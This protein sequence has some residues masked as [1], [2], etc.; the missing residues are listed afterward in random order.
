MALQ[1][2]PC[3]GALHPPKYAGLPRFRKPECPVSKHFIAALRP[4]GK[5]AAAV[6]RLKAPHHH[7]A[8]PILQTVAI[9]MVKN[10]QDIIEPFLRHHAALMDLVFVLENGS[11][12][13]TRSIVENLMH[14][15]GNIVMI[16]IPDRAQA[17]SRYVSQTL[18][19]V[20][21]AVFA[22]AVFFLDADEFIH[23]QSRAAL[24]DQVAALP[25]GPA[26]PLMLGRMPWRTFVP[27]PTLEEMATPDPLLR[28]RMRRKREVLRPSSSKVFLRLGGGF[29]ASIMC[30]QGNHKLR[31]G[32]DMRL[33]DRPTPM[34]PLLHLPVRSGAQLRVKA[35]AGWIANL[36]R[37]NDP[38][39]PLQGLDWKRLSADFASRSAPMTPADLA[40]EAMRYGTRYPMGDYASNAVA[41]AHGITPLRRYSDGS[42]GTAEALIEAARN[43]RP[44]HSQ[45]L[46]LPSAPQDAA[47][48]AP[49]LQY[50]MQLLRPTSVLA[51]HE[52]YCR[53]ARHH[54]AGDSA[55]WDAVQGQPAPHVAD[56]VLALDMAAPQ[57]LPAAFWDSCSGA[58][59]VA[60]ACAFPCADLGDGPAMLCA[61]VQWAR[62]GWQP[63]LLKTLAFRAVS[64]LPHLRRTALVLRPAGLVEQGEDANAALTAIADYP[65]IAPQAE[66][67]GLIT[68]AL[69]TPFPD[70]DQGYGIRLP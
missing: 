70:L 32:L 26:R 35:V 56:V 69:T 55:V 64:T 53:I 10:E 3:E 42:F 68:A 21:S 50:L 1:P 18:R 19:S 29:D 41:A 62:R 4:R 2:R 36:A 60:I 28:L 58:A 31:S 39:A 66:A 54:G 51:A 17:Q 57:G 11:A 25:I 30:E 16:D 43:P 14:E 24:L 33:P 37:K 22:D 45:T 61:L 5:I 15:L 34:M 46:D 27:D 48:D 67:K 8:R 63:D 59:K 9:A 65:H 6:A 47:F 7:G 38:L 52:G 40:E 13:A 23:V 44:M 12:D 20:Q 49:P